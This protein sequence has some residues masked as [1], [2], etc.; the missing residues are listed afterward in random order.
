M[1]STAN[2]V[3][4]FILA[5]LIVLAYLSMEPACCNDDH[6]HN[7]HVQ[8][9]VT[10][11]QSLRLHLQSGGPGNGGGALKIDLNR[12]GLQQSPRILT[13]LTT[14]GDRTA[15]AKANREA[16]EQ[17]EDG[18][19]ALVSAKHRGYLHIYDLPTAVCLLF[20]AV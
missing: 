1:P 17:R 20:S 3:V 16:M 18:Y 8:R 11:P 4:G 6:H 5:E 14:Y 2:W 12:A 7:T 9:G 19:E 13:L 15:F 10:R